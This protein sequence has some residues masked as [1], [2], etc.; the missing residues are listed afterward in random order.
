MDRNHKW[1]N[2]RDHLRHRLDN[3]SKWYWLPQFTKD[4]PSL[5]YMH[6]HFRLT[7]KGWRHPEH[8][9]RL[10]FRDSTRVTSHSYV[11]FHHGGWMTIF[12]YGCAL[13]GPPRMLM[14]QAVRLDLHPRFAVLDKASD[15]DFAL[16][17]QLASSWVKDQEAIE[18]GHIERPE[19][20][21]KLDGTSPYDPLPA[22]TFQ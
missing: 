16:F 12:T 22:F 7:S 13:R 18:I 1:Y 4:Y 3:E 20:K 9:M 8:I 21:S 19:W 14:K 2:L 11:Q 17:N 6:L 10:C 15:A 5:V